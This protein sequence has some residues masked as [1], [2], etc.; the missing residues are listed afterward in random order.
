MG[1]EVGHAFGF[2]G[3]VGV[4]GFEN[5]GEAHF[6]GAD[7]T[8]WGDAVFF[9]VGDLFFA[10]AVGLVDGALHGVGHLICVE[11]CPAFDVAG[12]AADGL[13]ER[14]LG[15][16]EAFLVGVEDG[17]EGD[18]GQ[19]EAFAEEVDA[20]EDVVLSL[21]E[22]AE[23]LDALKGFNL[24]VHVAAADA[25]FGVVAGEV[26]GHALGEGG[27]QDALVFCGAVADLGEEVVDLA[28]DGT[29][30]DDGVNEASGANDLFDDD[31]SGFGELIGARGGGD[32]YDLAGADF[33]LIEFERAVVH[34]GGQAE[35]VVDEVLL[36]A[37][38]AVPHAVELGDSDV[39]LVDEKEVVLGEVVEEGGRGLAGQTGGEVAGVV[40]NAVAEAYGLDH[41]EVEAGALVDALGLDEAA[42][43]F[44]L[45]FPPLHLGEDGGDGGGLA[46]GLDDVVGLGIDGEAGVLLTDGAEEG[47]DL[48]EGV[49]LVAEELD[50]VGVLVVGGVDL[51]DVATDA[52]G[53]ATEV[54]VVALVEDFDEA[55]GD[56]FTFELLAFFE[57]HQHTVVG[58]W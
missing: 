9:V 32:V 38:V 53:A 30:L 49:D 48:G 10:A 4:V 52:E 46:L 11:D 37:A 29:D 56:V 18:F 2:V 6:Q 12:G 55:A 45:L 43:G 27:D 35:A 42:L 40:L 23:E 3:E 34:G 5:A 20:D 51:D 24:G 28:F 50:A 39:G 31:A 14:A 57:K 19:V 54:D 58:L 15:A 1:G 7:D 41:L 26:F 16:E 25:D 47:V 21:A 13:D 44:E 8:G 33:E 36:A 22:I 17:N